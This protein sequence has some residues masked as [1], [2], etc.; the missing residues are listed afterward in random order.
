MKNPKLIIFFGITLIFTICSITTS[1]TVSNNIEDAIKLERILADYKFDDTSYTCTKYIAQSFG[2]DGNNCESYETACATIERGLSVSGNSDT[3]C[4]YPGHYYLSQTIDR[5]DAWWYIVSVGGP[6]VTILDGGNARQCMYVHDSSSPLVDGF[7]FQN[8][9]SDKGG[10]IRFYCIIRDWYP[11]L[12]NNIFVNN[13]GNKGGAI[14]NGLCST[15]LTNILIKNNYASS[16]GG[17]LYCN[18]DLGL[19][20]PKLSWTN[21]VIVDNTGSGQKNIYENS[22]QYNGNGMSSCNDCYNGGNCQPNGQCVCLPGSSLPTP[23][24]PFC[25]AGTYSTSVNAGSCTQCSQNTYNTGTGNTGCSS[26]PGGTTNSG[27]GNTECTPTQMSQPTFDSQT[28]T[29]FRLLWGTPPNFSVLGYKMRYK[30]YGGTD[31]TEVT[32]AG[33]VHQYTISN[34]YSGNYITQV[35]GYNNE[36]TGVWTLETAAST[37]SAVPPSPPP[38]SEDGSWKSSTSFGVTWGT[39]SNGGSPLIGYDLW[40][41]KADNQTWNIYSFG[42]DVHSFHITSIISGE[43]IL[44]VR[45]KSQLFIGDF[46]S[47]FSI[48]T[49]PATCPSVISSLNEINHTGDSISISWSAPA[50]NGGKALTNYQIAFLQIPAT[51]W[52]YQLVSP[53]VLE[54]TIP[55]L[56]YANYTIAIRALNTITPE[57]SLSANLTVETNPSTIPSPV[58]SISQTGKTSSSISISWVKPPNGGAIIL[59]YRIWYRYENATPAEDFYS[60][61]LFSTNLYYTLTSLLSGT[62]TIKMQ[63]NNSVGFSN[64]GTE[65]I[66]DTNPPSP[67]GVM[68]KPYK[69]SG[70]PTSITLGWF[71]PNDQGGDEVKAYQIQYK[72]STDQY[73]FD[74]V[75][76]MNTSL[77]CTIGGLEAETSY[78]F[79]IKAYNDAGWSYYWSAIAT[80]STDD[81]T[82]PDKV[83]IPSLISSTST[84]LGIEWGKP[85]DGGSDITSYNLYY[86]LTSEMFWNEI[87]IDLGGNPSPST[88]DYVLNDIYSGNYSIKISATNQ[89]GEGATSDVVVFETLQPTPPSPISNLLFINS[90][91]TSI[92]MSWNE[93]T[94]NGGRE[95][96]NFLIQYNGLSSNGSNGNISTNEFVLEYNL[97]NLLSDS[98]N[99]TVYAVNSIGESE[100]VLVQMATLSPDIPDIITGLTQISATSTSITVKWDKPNDNGRRI[101]NYIFSFTPYSTNVTQFIQIEPPTSGYQYQFSSLLS[102]TFDIAISAINEMGQSN[103]SEVLIASTSQ[104]TTP[105]Q[106]EQVEAT[107]LSSTSIKVNWKKPNNGGLN[108]TSYILSYRFSNLSIEN[109]T[110]IQISS[111]E[112]EYNI[113][114]LISGEYSIAMKAVNP[115]GECNEWSEDKNIS[116]F[117]AEVPHKVEELIPIEIRRTY[118][119]LSWNEPN[120]GGRYIEGYNVVCTEVNNPTN[121]IQIQVDTNQGSF[122]N[123]TTQTDYTITITPFNSIGFGNSSNFSI[124]TQTF[125]PS[126]VEGVFL[127]NLEP[128]SAVIGWQNLDDPDITTYTVLLDTGFNGTNFVSDLFSFDNL[129]PFTNYSVKVRAEINEYLGEWSQSFKFETNKTVPEIIDQLYNTQKSYNSL[130]IGWNK[131]R[132]NGESII[133]YELRAIKNENENETSETFT[134]S[135]GGVLANLTS[136]TN[137]SVEVRSSNEIGYSSWSS[138]FY[139]KTDAEQGP[140][141]KAGLYSGLGASVGA[142]AVVG[143]VAFYWYK[144]RKV[145]KVT[146]SVT[147]YSVNDLDEDE[148]DMK[149]QGD[150]DDIVMETVKT[151]KDLYLQSIEENTSKM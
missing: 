113:T 71:I 120:N 136:E 40:F 50:S 94:S 131:P 139:F 19:L 148:N 146:P 124:S 23:T 38:I 72:L 82:V 79:E 70:S 95:I 91:S 122:Y 41:H 151:E 138:K 51:T 100:G 62:Y 42:V 27:T 93:P 58:T 98:Y 81:S 66:M 123:L 130:S 36:G 145:V 7:T 114:K 53:D 107:T 65:F 86:K 39:G 9:N 12:R 133:Q 59:G 11:K 8:C 115:K 5:W 117:E 125:A 144:K 16:S 83:S 150:I 26:C 106:M 20:D 116:T 126:K 97:T 109:S 76:I 4:V 96:S 90:T 28:P 49:D 69:I 103:Y 128:Y 132:I 22:C 48:W 121:S 60:I 33:D 3:V 92:Y 44:K 147:V 37:L 112:N 46:S 43:Y 61:D 21:V 24:C 104:P 111:T 85:G 134:T 67:P 45:A 140:T 77:T 118:L 13:R 99:I 142:L 108:I 29:S 35:A 18:R 101:L 89:N 87:S 80:I 64:N 63:S 73:F 31:W 143:G 84:S 127:K 57:A 102:G 30:P 6:D 52:S 25:T 1:A 74:V 110:Q 149:E 32:L 88:N 17:G 129:I 78:D 34:L 75:N 119:I 14:Y 55:N 2:N 54:A 105:N 56:I 68:D 135:N 137:Y 141:S 15:E 47:D 10:A